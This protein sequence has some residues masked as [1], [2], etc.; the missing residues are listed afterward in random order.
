MSARVAVLGAG[1]TIGPAV[2]RDLAG[3]EEVERMLLIDLDAGRAREV[4]R[5][6]GGGRARVAE[7]GAP[8][9]EAISAC[10]VMVNAASYRVNLEAMEACLQAGCHY[11]DLGGLYWMT[12]RQLELGERFAAAGLLA[13]LGIGSSP[14]KTNLMAAVAARE[15][16]GRV[17]ALHVSAAGRDLDPPR[18]ESFPYALRTLLDEVTMAP[19]AVRD[20]RPVELEPL[21]PGG[22]V[23]FDQPIG[24]AETIHTLHSEMLTF[25]ASFGC[26]EASFRLALPGALLD[27]LR[28]LAAAPESEVRTAASAAAPPSAQT[29][30]VHLVE[31]SGGTRAIRVRAVTRPL[32]GWGIGGGVVSTAAPA[33]AVVRLLARD[34]IQARG[35]LP[36]EGCI[37]PDE[38]F[39]ELASRGTEVTVDAIEGAAL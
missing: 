14:G 5:R 7:P 24:A 12:A 3:S 20:G 22:A 29:V 11:V 35:A 16:E 33:A 19:V 9:A 31:A 15:L 17:D 25:P 8:L 26:T 2:V 32:P 38:M 37:D 18:G 28:E 30:A 27:R 23:D 4:K 6:H 1:G 34:R 36:P 10:D 39:A 13:V 21:A